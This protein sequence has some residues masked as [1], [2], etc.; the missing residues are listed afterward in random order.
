MLKKAA[1]T[2]VSF[3]L[4]LNYQPFAVNAADWHMYGGFPDRKF[5][6]DS[7]KILP[8]GKMN[9]LDPRVEVSKPD[10]RIA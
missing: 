8:K 7:E 4:V 10:L 2:I 9:N 3:L 6:T 5:N 1:L